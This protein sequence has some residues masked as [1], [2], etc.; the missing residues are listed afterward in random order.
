MQLR[1]LQ[2]IFVLIMSFIVILGCFNG[3]NKINNSE[4]KYPALLGSWGTEDGDMLLTFG[5]ASDK[6]TYSGVLSYYENGKLTEDSFTYTLNYN[7]TTKLNTLCTTVDDYSE[8]YEIELKEDVLSLIIY[9]EETA[10]KEETVFI[11]GKQLVKPEN[12][13]NSSELKATTVTS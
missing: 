9:S 10:T 12:T 3:C 8:T 5:K 2:R 6:N 11:K 4:I 13:S 1:D 7:K